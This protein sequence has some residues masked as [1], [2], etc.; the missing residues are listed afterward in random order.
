MP[1]SV[2]IDVKKS[3]EA[4]CSWQKVFDTLAN[5]PVSASFFPKVKNLEDLGDGV[6]KWE[7]EKIGVDRYSIQTIY[8]CKYTSNKGEGW[9]KWEPVAGIGNGVVS[10]AWNLT[11]LAPQKTRINFAVKG[12]LTIPLPGLL[13]FLIAPVVSVAFLGMISRYHRNLRDFFAK[14]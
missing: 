13:R 11:S 5:V 6:F 10:G 1:I 9:V 14:P 2:K 12:E 8:A 3:F 7:M 4:D